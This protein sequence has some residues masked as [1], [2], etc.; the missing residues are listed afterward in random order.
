MDELANEYSGSEERSGEASKLGLLARVDRL[1]RRWLPGY[2]F[3][4]GRRLSTSET[5]IVQGTQGVRG[6]RKRMNNK[7][8]VYLDTGIAKSE[9]CVHLETLLR[10]KLLKKQQELALEHQEGRRE[11][12]LEQERQLNQLVQQ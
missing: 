9:F 1:L 2:S 4:R 7:E 3:I 8:E 12:E 10:N 6:R 11:M 5:S